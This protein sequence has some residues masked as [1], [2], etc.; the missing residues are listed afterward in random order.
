MKVGFF[1][2]WFLV[3]VLC[4]IGIFALASEGVRVHFC[5]NEHELE[6][7]KQLVEDLRN[8]LAAQN[9]V[10]LTNFALARDLNVVD[11]RK[12]ASRF[13]REGLLGNAQI[14]GWEIYARTTTSTTPLGPK[15]G[16]T[17]KNPALAAFLSFLIPGLG[18]LYA[19][20]TTR[21]IIMLIIA[22]I[23]FPVFAILGITF[24][25]AVLGD[26]PLFLRN[27]ELFLLVLL[28]ISALSILY[29]IFFIFAIV[30]AAY[31]ASRGY[32]IY[33]MPL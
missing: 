22:F 26:P 32:G 11:V 24:L 16:H 25:L 5:G 9:K 12:R 1:I 20:E 7:Q 28:L 13:I 18:Q 19:G 2:V 21:G 30:D 8:Q 17:D 10:N 15:I 29:I 6:F 33:I 23:V 3:V 14:V 31:I 27:P 4:L